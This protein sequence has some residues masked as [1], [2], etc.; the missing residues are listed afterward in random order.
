[1]FPEERK[2]KIYELVCDKKSIKVSE[3]SRILNIS[4]VTIRRDLDELDSQNKLHRTHGGAVAAYAVGIPLHLRDLK[5]RNTE[6]KKKIAACAYN[7]IKDNDTILIDSS[8]TVHELLKLIITGGKKNLIIVTTSIV[9]LTT[10]NGNHNH[11]VIM[12][13]GEVSYNAETVEGTIA[14]EF[15]KELRA[16]KSFI[17][18][19]G[20]DEKFG[21][22]TPRFEDAEIKKSIINSSLQSFILADNTK[23][24]KTYLAKVKASC[25][26]VITDSRRPGCQYD[27]LEDAGA[28]LFAT[29]KPILQS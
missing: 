16:D 6:E 14:N 19:N 2:Q 22:S 12:V 9:S 18:I 17:G 29:Q 3:L 10:L 1:M 11:K 21:Y 13:G 26:F 5:S 4:E 25:D 28:I 23:F 7:H 24:G 15:I 27:W 20:I 8:S